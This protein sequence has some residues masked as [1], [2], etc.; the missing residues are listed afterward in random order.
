MSRSLVIYAR[1]AMVQLRHK[2]RRIADETGIKS[3]SIGQ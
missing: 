3:R 2:E 1:I